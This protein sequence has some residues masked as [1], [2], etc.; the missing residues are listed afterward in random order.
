MELLAACDH[1][2]CKC[3]VQVQMEGNNREGGADLGD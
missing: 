2:H 1:L 3:K